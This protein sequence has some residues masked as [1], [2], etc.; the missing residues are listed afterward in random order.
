ME[1][2]TCQTSA[3]KLSDLEPIGEGGFGIV[4]RAKHVD[5]GT[6]AY[7][8]MLIGVITKRDDRWELSYNNGFSVLFIVEP[9]SNA[10][11]QSGLVTFT[12]VCYGCRAVLI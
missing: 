11:I 7:K 8:K 3:K 2:I 5:Y 9:H 4:F 10:H 12:T 6:V 1:S